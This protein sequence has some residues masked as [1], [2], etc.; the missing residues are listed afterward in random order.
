MKNTD[1]IGSVLRGKGRE[2]Y[3][4]APSTCVYDALEIMADKEI[5]ALLVMENGRAVG[6]VSERDYARKV[7]LQGR[8][9]KDTAVSEIMTSDLV[10]VTP[11]DTVDECMRLMTEHRVRHLPVMANG[12]VVG[13]VSLGDLVKWIIDSQEQEI[14]HLHAYIAGAYPAA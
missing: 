8:L 3:S 13:M 1:T 11:E 12:D 7:I 10:S 9:S 4:V 14:R 5:G 6:L 2:V